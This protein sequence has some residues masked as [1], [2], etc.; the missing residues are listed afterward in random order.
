MQIVGEDNKIKERA[1]TKQG[2]RL[3]LI[4]EGSVFPTVAPAEIHAGWPQNTHAQV[5]KV[6]RRPVGIFLRPIE[7]DRVFK[8]LAQRP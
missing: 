4:P 8:V 1:R 5:T 7:I 2:S 6:Q 3:T